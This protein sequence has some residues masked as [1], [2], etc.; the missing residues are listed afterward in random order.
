MLS[1]ILGLLAMLLGMATAWLMVSG[2]S[3]EQDPDARF[4][5]GFC[6]FCVLAPLALGAA[7]VNP[8][9]G[10]AVLVAACGACLATHRFLV[11]EAMQRTAVQTGSRLLAEHS[12]F[13]SRHD[14]VLRQW[15]RYELDPA[16]AIASP[17]MNDVEVPETAALAKAL[18]QAERLRG[19]QPN[20]A[21][22]GVRV[23][24]RRAVIELES[25]FTRAEQ[26]LAGSSGRMVPGARIPPGQ[27]AP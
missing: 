4:W 3:L 15:S 16:A 27:D 7:L 14:Q 6:G 11:H 21:V 1:P 23:D 25:A 10:V 24:Y 19:R 18:A 2:P 22:D 13:E 17:G 5:Y 8:L 9:A 20:G 26:S 12:A